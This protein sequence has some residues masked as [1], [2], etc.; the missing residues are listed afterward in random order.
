MKVSLLLIVVLVA[1][2]PAP[3]RQQAVAFRAAVVGVSPGVAAL[4]LKSRG[5][6]LLTLT[7]KDEVV[8]SSTGQTIALS[9]LNA[10]DYVYVQGTLSGGDLHASEVR[11]LD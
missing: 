7:V 1:C 8:R 5:V 11:R 3:L 6:P 2:C 10:G 9:S 4:H